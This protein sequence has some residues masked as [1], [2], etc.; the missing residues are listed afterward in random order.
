MLK[1]YLKQAPGA[2]PH[3]TVHKDAPLSEFEQV[4]AQ[5]PV[6]R[7]VPESVGC[8]SSEQSHPAGCA[9]R[10]RAGEGLPSGH[11]TPHNLWP[12]RP[13]RLHA[14]PPSRK[15]LI[16]LRL[17]SCVSISTP[18]GFFDRDSIRPRASLVETRPKR[19]KELMS[20]LK[21]ILSGAAL[22]AAVGIVHAQGKSEQK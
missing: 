17:L 7:V 20:P 3:L 13:L 16:A 10:R 2:R 9:E 18:N 11:D 1:A 19:E 15:R 12:T 6:F 8:M 22:L 14:V 21:M 4:A 5:F